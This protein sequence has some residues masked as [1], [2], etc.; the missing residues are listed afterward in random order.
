MKMIKLTCFVCKEKHSYAAH[1]INPTKKCPYCGGPADVEMG[2]SEIL[3]IDGYEKLEA[4][5]TIKLTED[6]KEQD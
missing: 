4:F 1:T 5:G 3:P 2:I 6:K